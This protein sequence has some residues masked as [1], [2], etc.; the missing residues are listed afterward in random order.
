MALNE[1]VKNHKVTLHKQQQLCGILLDI[2]R[3]HDPVVTSSLADGTADHWSDVDITLTRPVAVNHVIERLCQDSRLL[4]H[5][6]A[7]HIGIPDLIV[8][9]WDMERGIAKADILVRE[10][11]PP[12]PLPAAV[13]FNRVAGWLIYTHSKIERGEFLEAASGL[14]LLGAQGIAPILQMERH[15]PMEGYRRFEQRLPP[16]LYDQLWTFRPT[17]PDRAELRRALDAIL[18]FLQSSDRAAPFG[19][20]RRLGRIVDDIRRDRERVEY[21][22]QHD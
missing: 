19:N 5:F 17:G 9:L 1:L 2:L 6:T 22:K 13:L 12:A 4:A 16:S 10:L 8:T 15:L 20:E 3:E 18:V 7:D 11:P 21:V 14:Q